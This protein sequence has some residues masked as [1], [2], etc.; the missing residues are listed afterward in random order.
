MSVNL[1]NFNY[2]Q[3]RTISSFYSRRT[4]KT[5]YSDDVGNRASICDDEPI[6]DDN[7]G[8]SKLKYPSHLQSG[9][10]AKLK[11]K[12]KYL[13]YN[14]YVDKHL[15]YGGINFSKNYKSSG[16][17]VSSENKG[18][19]KKVKIKNNSSKNRINTLNTNNVSKNFAYLRKIIL[20]LKRSR[21]INNNVISEKKFKQRIYK[22]DKFANELFKQ[23]GY[24][25]NINIQSFNNNKLHGICI[26]IDDCNEESSKFFNQTSVLFAL[27]HLFTK[28]INLHEECF[29][30]IILVNKKEYK[31][32]FKILMQ[33]KL[34][35]QEIVK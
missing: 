33:K 9:I 19:N 18:V 27:N 5:L 12:N 6:I 20:L 28:I 30:N 32:F 34:L 16:K 10:L 31:N 7:I 2:Y 3:D 15:S 17:L 14:K 11:Y 1:F 4:K 13:K 23:I 22:T 25:V 24:N 29:S 26:F 8:N 35:D 21:Y